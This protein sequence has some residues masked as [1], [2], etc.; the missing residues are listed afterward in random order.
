MHAHDFPTGHC[1]CLPIYFPSIESAVLDRL[2][3]HSSVV[4]EVKQQNPRF[5]TF[6]TEPSS[7]RNCGLSATAFTGLPARRGPEQVKA[8]F[9]PI[10]T[11]R[12]KK[13]W[14]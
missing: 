9:D 12:Q 7:D 3:C 2:L 10:R 4:H 1:V 6:V 14:S 13:R 8:V 11:E 5:W